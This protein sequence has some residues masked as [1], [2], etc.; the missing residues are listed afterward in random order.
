[1]VPAA[2]PIAPSITQKTFLAKAPLANLIVAPAAVVKA[3]STLI[4]NKASGFPPA[5]KVTFVSIDV[6]P[7]KV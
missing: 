6:A 7:I 4:I 1:M 3:P 5:S 2:K